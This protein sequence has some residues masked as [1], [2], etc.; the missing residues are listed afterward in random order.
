[1]EDPGGVA[2]SFT[3][4]WDH[5]GVVEGGSSQR[6]APPVLYAQT[7]EGGHVGYQ[8]FGEGGFS[9]VIFSEWAASIETVWEH[10][11]HLRIQQY[12]ASFSRCLFFDPR[13]VGVSDPV[14]PERIGALGS[15]V[16]DAVTAM[17]AAGV[18]RAV[19]IGEGFGGHAAVSLSAA[20][21][22]RVEALVLM[23][24][25]PSLAKSP[26]RP[27]G[28]TNEGID[29]TV[30]FVRRTWG[31]GRVVYADVPALGCDESFLE[32]CGRFERVAASP[33]TAAHWVRAAYTSDVSAL[34]PQVE[35]RTAVLY[36]GDLAHVPVE[37]TR[38]LA[39]RVPGARFFEL[40][41][42]SFY[43]FDDPETTREFNDFVFGP[44]A[45]D[46]GARELATVVFVDIVDSTARAAELGDGRW[47]DVLNGVDAFV[48]RTV[49]R[50]GGRTVKQTGDGHLTT[51]PVPSN[52]LRASLAI[53]RGIAALG[54]DI[55]TGVNTGEVQIRPGGDLS[56]IGVNVAARTMAAAEPREI[57]VTESVA[58]LVAGSSFAFDERGTHRLKGVPGEWRLLALLG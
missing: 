39:A 1:M 43:W 38:D 54:V 28:Q 37:A 29:R 14:P 52:A 55:R 47:E 35:V 33:A 8:V 25:Y 45:D 16:E 51:F 31:T 44:G 11:V 58:A 3:R 6:V 2:L 40:T 5:D 34:L 17:N 30:E 23:N 18:S 32:F 21:P 57:L 49:E 41:E 26:D 19:V 20:H 46:R 7:A 10:P 56:G 36:T 9:V 24:V 42:P 27:Y 4:D 13:G 50:F 48:R 15:W 22:E 12:W 53:N